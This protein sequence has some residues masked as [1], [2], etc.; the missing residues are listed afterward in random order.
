[1]Y[2]LTRNDFYFPLVI[3]LLKSSRRFPIW[4]RRLIVRAIALTAYGVSASKRRLV[5]RG[6]N[7][8]FEGLSAGQKRAMAKRVFYQ[9]WRDT[10]SMAPSNGER[11]QIK[12]IAVRGEEHLRSALSRGA[13]VI[14]ME[15]NSFGDRVLARWVLHARGYALHQIHAATHLGSG[16]TVAPGAPSWA[17]RRLRRF[18]EACEMESVAE[19]IYLGESDSLAFIRVLLDRLKRNSIVCIAG[20]GKQSQRLIEVPFLGVK[21][22]FSP[23]MFSLART[24]GAV[25]LPLFCVRRGDA[26]FE[27]V[28]GPPIEVNSAAGREASLTAAV[29][30]FTSL[31]ES[32]CREYPEQ[33]YGAADL[34]S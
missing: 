11:R 3:V 16:F 22:E 1:M 5:W 9:F 31:L 23:G 2:R 30:E 18:L 19:I 13:G 21:R 6:I 27:V 15:T 24:S 7:A 26:G 34:A 20:D 17:A 25:V 4:L 12:E 33:F 32:Y 29:H 14:L 28:I 10:F 8:G